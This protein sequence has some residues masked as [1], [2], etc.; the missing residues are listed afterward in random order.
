MKLNFPQVETAR[1][2]L[3]VPVMDDA[4]ALS[5]IWSDPEVTKFIPLIMFRTIDELKE[6][7]PLA[8]QRWEE[9]GFGLFAVTDKENDETIGY[10]G[11]QFLNG[12]QDVEI[13]YGFSRESWDR[14]FATEAAGAVMRFAFEKMELASITGVTQPE[15]IASQKVLEKIGLEKNPETR[16]FYETE[17][18]FFT[19]SRENFSPDDSPY[20]LTYVEQGGE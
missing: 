10:C 13:F 12:S 7:I 14:G 11:L 20:R 4:E 9:R 17:C 1:L 19:G 5:S 3:R 2:R 15:N 8:R 16:T 6:F 18:A